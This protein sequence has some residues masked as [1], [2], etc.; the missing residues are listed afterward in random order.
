M[1]PQIEGADLTSI[2]TER[3]SLPEGDYLVQVLNSELSEDKRTLI[4]KSEIIEPAEA[5]GREYWE[6]CN[7]VKNNGEP[8]EIGYQTLKRYLEAVFGKGSPESNRADSD[9]L[10]GHQVRLYLVPNDFTRKDGSTG[11]GNKAK[12]IMAA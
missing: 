12:K 10:H 11:H 7:I 3:E 6:F 5:A 2:S 8:N 4:I 9:P 1:C